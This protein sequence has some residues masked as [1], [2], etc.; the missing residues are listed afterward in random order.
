[1]LY[2]EILVFPVP[3]GKIFRHT[4]KGTPRNAKRKCKPEHGDVGTKPECHLVKPSDK[5]TPLLTI[6]KH[7][8]H[9]E[10]LRSALNLVDDD[11]TPKRRERR[12]GVRETRE[13]AGIFQIEDRGGSVP[14]AGDL[15]GQ[16]RLADLPWPE[17]R[18]HRARPQQPFDLDQLGGA[19]EHP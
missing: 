8:Q 13:V 15:T 10:Q 3:S 18:H 5:A 19:T 1:M 6:W 9:R 11:Q 2:K 17:D 7:A 12:R 4:A 14:R 16:R